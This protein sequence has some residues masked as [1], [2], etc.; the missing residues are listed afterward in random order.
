MTDVADR[1]GNG[2]FGLTFPAV[3]GTNIGNILRGFLR[4]FGDDQTIRKKTWYRDCFGP[5]FGDCRGGGRAAFVARLGT[6]LRG[7]ASVACRARHLPRVGL[8][9]R[10]ASPGL[11][12]ACRRVERRE[13]PHLPILHPGPIGSAGGCVRNR[14]PFGRASHFDDSAPSC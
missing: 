10:G 9:G 8:C 5:V 3:M 14:L 4:Y 7:N 11:R 2:P 1:S 12:L 6:R 13:L